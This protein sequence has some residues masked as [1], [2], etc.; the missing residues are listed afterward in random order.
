M[1]NSVFK[2]KIHLSRTY[3]SY[4]MPLCLSFHTNFFLM[5]GIFNMTSMLFYSRIY[6]YMPIRISS[7]GT[8]TTSW[9]FEEI[10]SS[11]ATARERNNR[12]T[13]GG[14][15]WLVR[16]DG[17]GEPTDSC[18][19]GAVTSPYISRG[20]TV[21]LAIDCLR[22]LFT[23]VWLPSIVV[24]RKWSKTNCDETERLNLRHYERLTHSNN[25]ELS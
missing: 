25:F 8:R 15:D 4:M 11:T 21:Q 13:W 10:L 1:F 22:L 6:L 7:R 20:M 24:A 2:I 23:P 14:S 19:S 17:I 18:G 5:W 12:R 9:C 16:P 3:I